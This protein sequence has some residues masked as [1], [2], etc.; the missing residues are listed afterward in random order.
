LQKTKQN[1]FFSKNYEEKVFSSCFHDFSFNEETD[2]HWALFLVEYQ[3]IINCQL[4]I[5]N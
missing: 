3:L 5:V 4:S 2:S 1:T